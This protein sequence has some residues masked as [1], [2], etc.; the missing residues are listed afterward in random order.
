[1]GERLKTRLNS[2]YPHFLPNRLQN[3]SPR[4]MQLCACMYVCI[5]SFYHIRNKHT[6]CLG[7]QPKLWPKYAAKQSPSKLRHTPLPPPPPPTKERLQLPSTG[8]QVGRK[9]SSARH[10]SISFQAY[11][12]Y[13][14][15]VDTLVYKYWAI[16]GI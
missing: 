14:I 7:K 1:M 2:S 16:V 4:Y 15:I 10:M 3:G 12:T 8:V 5:T 11:Y 13:L 6:H 9:A